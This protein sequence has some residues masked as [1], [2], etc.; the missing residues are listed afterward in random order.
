MHPLA[1]DADHAP[2]GIDEPGDQ[3]ELLQRGHFVKK[4]LDGG[5]DQ[6]FGVGLGQGSESTGQNEW[7]RCDERLRVLKVRSC[8]VLVPSV[9]TTTIL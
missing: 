4:P 5:F 6:G 3:L 2:R 8:P 9:P 1:I 7:T